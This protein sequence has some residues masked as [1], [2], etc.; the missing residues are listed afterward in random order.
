MTEENNIDWMCK[1]CG[2]D[3]LKEWQK[4]NSETLVKEKDYVK[5]A[6]TCYMEDGEENKEWMWIE[7]EE[8]GI[9]NSL[10]R[11]RIDN[12]AI[13]KLKH[14]LKYGDSVYFGRDK[15]ADHLKY[16]KLEGSQTVQTYRG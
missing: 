14:N 8:V 12:E 4:E 7:V 16:K 10:I 9:N 3:R 13:H 11:G 1:D 2:E 15:I 6:F 5:I